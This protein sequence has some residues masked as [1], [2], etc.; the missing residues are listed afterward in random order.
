GKCGRR[1]WTTKTDLG[2][3]SRQGREADVKKPALE[4]EQE[5]NGEELSM[6]NCEPKEVGEINCESQL[7]EWERRFE[8]SVFAG[9]PRLRFAFDP[10]LGR[11]REIGFVIEESFEH[12]A[13][14]V[15]RETNAEGDQTWQ[16]KNFL[17]PCLVAL[18]VGL[19]LNKP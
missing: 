18:D 2:P 19:S 17:H 13:R 12:G 10:V 6:D 14:V 4:H 3:A 16:K 5:R 9:P 7:C 1:R 15:E 11:S 8:R